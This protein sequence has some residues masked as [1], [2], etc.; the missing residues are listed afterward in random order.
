[1]KRKL[2]VILLS[3]FYALSGIN[4]QEATIE[5]GILDLRYQ[6]YPDQ[7]MD[8]IGDW[9]FYWDKHLL[10]ADFKNK[11]DLVPDIF[12][13]VPSYWT[14]FTNEIPE[15]SGTGYAT[16]RLRI[17]IPQSSREEISFLLPVFDSSYR[18]Y[19]DGKYVNANGVPGTTEETT[20]PGY[21]P[22]KY[23]FLPSNDTVEIVVNVSNFHHRRGGF[24]LPVK[25]GKT[26]EIELENKRDNIFI[27]LSNG[28]LLAFIGFYFLFFAVFRDDRTMLY[29]ALALLGILFRTLFTGSY[30]ILF[31]FDVGWQWLVKIE[32][33]SSFLA[34]TFSMWYF[35]YIY[36]DRIVPWINT[37]LTVVFAIAS[38][39]TLLTPVSV[40]SYTMLLFVP[41]VIILLVYYF[42]RSIVE[43]IRKGG[44]WTFITIGFGALLIGSLNDIFIASGR[45]L[46]YNEYL[47]SHTLIFFILT[48]VIVL[49]Y[50]WV[51]TSKKEKSLLD[52]IEFVNK[53]LENIV[54]ERTTELTNQKGELEEQK[55]VTD[56]KNSELEKTI[57]VKNRIFSIIAHDLKSPVLN[58]SL[59]IDHLKNNNDPEVQQSVINSISQQ[60][61]FATNLIDNLLIWGEQQQNKI[62]YKPEHI[63]LTDL[64]LEN[65]NLFRAPSDRKGIKMTYSHKGNPMAICDKDLINIVLRNLLSN[66]IKFTGR[67][68]SI[69]VSVEE[70]VIKD[71]MI[72]I[73]I[74]DNGV[75]IP[76]D[77]LIKILQ[78][79]II[80]SSRG[81]EDEKGTGLGLQLCNDLIRINKGSLSITSELKRGTTITIMLPSP[82][83]A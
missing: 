78:D 5:N 77:K 15:I 45:T 13:K 65:F 68:G 58:L 21:R 6:G 61:G 3:F 60:S 59:M 50:R 29:F 44:Y 12:I 52:E 38:L 64:I 7:Q 66:A 11:P 47:L 81:T 32:Y 56:T 55:K 9:E 67:K 19:F 30:T 18:I 40:F 63:N 28:M 10:P 46:F 20:K 36:K 74:K 53:N 62:E 69:Y 70:P 27:S 71:G 16:Y 42:I 41:V 76:E 17:I 4:G 8:L 80:D 75:G 22:F 1:M 31:F 14:D 73:K 49:I 82:T 57:S 51:E 34:V 37:A 39:L 79:E 25:F 54:I 72:Y 26:D 43:A 23:S 2:L 83:K 33:L 48:Q 35:Y 24:W